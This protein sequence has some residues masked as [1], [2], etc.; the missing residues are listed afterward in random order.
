VGVGA[1][2]VRRF[3]TLV[4]AGCDA[5]ADIV[6]MTDAEVA[7]FEYVCVTGSVLLPRSYTLCVS[8]HR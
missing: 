2:I 3:A 1:S 5:A 6:P 7:A 8:T 4:G